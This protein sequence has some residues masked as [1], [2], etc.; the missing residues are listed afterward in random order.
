MLVT[1]R[2]SRSKTAGHPAFYVTESP[3][4]IN[5]SRH[6]LARTHWQESRYQSIDDTIVQLFIS[7]ASV[8]MTRGGGIQ[9]ESSQP[10]I[11]EGT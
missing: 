1:M 7:Q 9:S 10:G 4:A 8:L 3:V 11:G 6:F 2:Q 5:G